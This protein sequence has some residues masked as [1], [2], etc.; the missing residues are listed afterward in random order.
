MWNGYGVDD[1]SE[2]EERFSWLKEVFL[3]DQLP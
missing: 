1:E 3:M 2:G